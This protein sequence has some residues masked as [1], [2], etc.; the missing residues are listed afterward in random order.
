MNWKIM[1]S[2]S[3]KTYVVGSSLLF[4]N[5]RSFVA[6]IAFC[7]KFITSS[8]IFSVIFF[9]SDENKVPAINEKTISGGGIRDFLIRI[10]VSKESS[11]LYKIIN[12]LKSSGEDRKSTRLNSSHAN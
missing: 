7:T 5:I 12:S 2:F 1:L 3:K 11:F 8:D 6:K 9:L 10:F 4:L